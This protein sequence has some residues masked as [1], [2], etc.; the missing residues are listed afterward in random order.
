MFKI[1]NETYLQ[2]ENCERQGFDRLNLIF[3]KSRIAVYAPSKFIKIALGEHTEKTTLKRVNDF[4]YF[5]G[6]NN[7]MVRNR[8]NNVTIEFIDAFGKKIIYELD[9][10]NFICLQWEEF[11]NF[12]NPWQNGQ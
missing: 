6:L 8:Q 2:W 12:I 10:D 1:A 11:C 3:H 9:K 5:I 7:A 4:L